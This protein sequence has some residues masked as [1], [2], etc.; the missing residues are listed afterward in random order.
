MIGNKIENDPVNHP[1]HYMSSS[2]LETL[3]VINAFTEDLEG[4]DAVYTSQVIKYICRWNKKNG[5]ED[6]KKAEFYL[7]KLIEKKENDVYG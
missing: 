6:L 2:G 7:K 1:N 5:L 3:D 4:M